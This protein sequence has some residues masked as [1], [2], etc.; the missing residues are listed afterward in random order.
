M[1]IK[2]EI[3]R[4]CFIE[5]T[6]VTPNG[7]LMREMD[8]MNAVFHLW[9]QWHE[10][11]RNVPLN[12]WEPEFWRQIEENGLSAQ[13]PVAYQQGRIPWGNIPLAYRD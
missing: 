9:N 12:I 11:Y 6:I 3:N 7:E 8:Y 13:P 5:D 1:K 2:K 10:F 4:H